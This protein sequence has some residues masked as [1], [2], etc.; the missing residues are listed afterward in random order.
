MISVLLPLCN[1]LQTLAFSL[2]SVQA[3]AP[4]NAGF[5]RAYG[6][7]LVRGGTCYTL[8]LVASTL[9]KIKPVSS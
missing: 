5:T 4:R 6:G 3:K 8:L 9:L 7:N 2:F 1:S